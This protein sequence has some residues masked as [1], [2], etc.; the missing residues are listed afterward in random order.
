MTR[1]PL[2]GQPWVTVWIALY[3]QKLEHKSYGLYQKTIASID[4]QEFFDTFKIPNSFNS[5]FLITELHVWLLMVRAMAEGADRG[6][7]GQFIRN[8]IVK[9]MWADINSRLNNLHYDGL[10]SSQANQGVSIFNLHFQT[11]VISYDEGILGDDKILA[12]AL[13]VQFFNCDC[14]DLA[15]IDLLVKYVRKTVSSD[16]FFLLSLTDSQILKP[17]PWEI[18]PIFSCFSCRHG[19]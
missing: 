2:T 10:R 18:Y 11:S 15:K 19:L 17:K 3:L 5:W 13:W 1:L 12:N 4:Y 16:W 9:G 8:S 7:D 6:A 14:D